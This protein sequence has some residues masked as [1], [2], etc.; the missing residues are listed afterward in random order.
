[1]SENR[2]LDVLKTAFNS[3]ARDC[4]MI[5][6]FTYGLRFDVYATDYAHKLKVKHALERC[7]EAGGITHKSLHEARDYFKGTS[8]DGVKVIYHCATD[9]DISVDREELWMFHNFS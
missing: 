5:I 1:M 2:V 3:A 8:D 9:T 4:D 6:T 7:Q